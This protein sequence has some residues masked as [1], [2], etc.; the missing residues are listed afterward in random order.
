MRPAVIANKQAA[1]PP[2]KRSHHVSRGG[3]LMRA[4]PA[5]HKAVPAAKSG[6]LPAGPA[7]VPDSSTPSPIANT[8]KPAA[9]AS[10]PARKYRRASRLVATTKA[11][12]SI[13]HKLAWRVGEA[14]SVPASPNT[15]P[16]SRPPAAIRSR[17]LL[18]F[19]VIVSLWA[20]GG[21]LASFAVE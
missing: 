11:T 13:A 15:A 5:A 3:A 20:E 18:G 1:P 16:T 4:S 21:G 7:A 14:T 19:E 9:T 8:K 10:T 12:L 6:R 17:V 2:N